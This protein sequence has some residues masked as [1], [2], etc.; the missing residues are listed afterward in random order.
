MCMYGLSCEKEKN[1]FHL[2]HTNISYNFQML[3]CRVMC[4]SIL[5]PVAITCMSHLS[6]SYALWHYRFIKG[7]LFN[8]RSEAI[9]RLGNSS[10][11]MMSSYFILQ[12]LS[13]QVSGTWPQVKICVYSVIDNRKTGCEIKIK[14]WKGQTIMY[15]VGRDLK[16]S[17]L[18]IKTI[19]T[20]PSLSQLVAK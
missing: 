16:T 11:M 1:R 15:W 9:K 20:E 4:K 17:K 2:Y 19:V 8:R 7:C 12:F 3:L 10:I 13:Q 5:V 18:E 6:D 14:Y